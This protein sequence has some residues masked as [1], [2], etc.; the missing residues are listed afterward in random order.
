MPIPLALAAAWPLVSASLLTA[1]RYVAMTAVPAVARFAT[2]P[3]TLSAAGTAFNVAGN[4]VKGAWNN[5]LLVGTTMLTADGL[6][7]TNMTSTAVKGAASAI[8][9]VA[10]YTVD[11]VKSN[12]KDI[13]KSVTGGKITSTVE[14]ATGGGSSGQTV[15]QAGS[16]TGNQQ[17]ATGADDTV[18][19]TDENGNTVRVPRQS[20]Q[21]GGFNVQ[22][23]MSGIAEK[24]KNDPAMAL[25]AAF[26]AMV[27]ISKSNG[28]MEAAWKVPL[29]SAIFGMAFK[30]LGPI[31]TPI[32]GALGNGLQ[33]TLQS[34]FHGAQVT[35]SA[36]AAP[37]AATPAPTTA[38]VADTALA[39]A[40]ASKFQENAASAT[41]DMRL[42]N[43]DTRV[44]LRNRPAVNRDQYALTMNG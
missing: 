36:S 3:S 35:P 30:L 37:S 41:T 15:H 32:L 38:P 27:G 11:G 14:A 39:A 20:Q 8:G 43:G 18:I 31:L 4:V 25:G 1:G 12:A 13:D 22:N 19:T 29:Y 28:M 17:G 9:A 2:A 34:S 23:F 33:S 44:D 5:K 24:A 40:N 10:G 6:L 16:A 21:A 7:G 42:T 26:G